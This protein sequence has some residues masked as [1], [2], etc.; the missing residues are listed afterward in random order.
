MMHDDNPIENRQTAGHALFFAL[1]TTFG[2][3]AALHLIRAALWHKSL[4]L[5]EVITFVL[6]ALASILLLS[7]IWSGRPEKT[8][9][10]NRHI[11]WISVLAVATTIFAT[12]IWPIFWHWAFPSGY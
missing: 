1:A 11:L 9:S 12:T 8:W 6:T 4:P 7:V 10:L 3:G 5:S 2:G